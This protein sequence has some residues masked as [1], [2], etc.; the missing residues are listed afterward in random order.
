[1]RRSG[2]DVLR[3]CSFS[4][5]RYR[6]G[7]TLP[8]RHNGRQLKVRATPRISL[9][10]G[11]PAR[12]RE[13]QCASAMSG[14][15]PPLAWR[16]SSRPWDLHQPVNPAVIS[17]AY[18]DGMDA[19]RAVGWH[20]GPFLR[21]LAHTFGP[22]EYP[23]HLRHGLHH[24]PCCRAAIAAA[25]AF[26]PWRVGKDFGSSSGFLPSSHSLQLQH[27]V[28][29]NP[30]PAPTCCSLLASAPYPGAGGL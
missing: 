25:A 30:T 19:P 22:Q 11:G 27:W 10:S 12:E 6:S 24:E 4:G 23:D 15:R 20:L 13:R 5:L 9:T 26:S 17:A 3:M 1:M 21:S 7:T 29:G 16:S 8:L 28:C 14:P 2:N 18:D